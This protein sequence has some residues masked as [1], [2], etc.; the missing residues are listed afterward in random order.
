LRWMALDCSHWVRLADTLPK[1][2]LLLN[3]LLL[4]ILSFHHYKLLCY[5]L[6]FLRL[7]SLTQLPPCALSTL[8]LVLLSQ[9]LFFIVIHSQ[10]EIWETTTLSIN[11][12]LY[13][14]S[15]FMTFYAAFKVSS[16]FF[17]F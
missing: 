5:T 16:S 10:E 3:L 8:D 1:N 9:I 4:H 15:R 2:A 13:S 7:C 14:G 6:S 11:N 17:R 12:L